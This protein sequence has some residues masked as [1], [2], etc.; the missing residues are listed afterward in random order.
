MWLHDNMMRQQISYKLA[1]ITL[2]FRPRSITRQDRYITIQRYN[3]IIYRCITCPR[4]LLHVWATKK[5]WQPN[6]SN[7][8]YFVNTEGNFPKG[9]HVIQTEKTTQPTN[10][11]INPFIQFNLQPTTRCSFK[12][13]QQ[14]SLVI[15]TH[16]NINNLAHNHNMHVPIS[17]VM[18]L[19]H[20]SLQ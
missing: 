12:R 9:D 18:Q 15:Q 6:F 8:W 1:S 7:N 4:Y 14:P 16:E 2:K 17:K 13:L 20:K 11:R 3:C 10:T 5:H 19:E